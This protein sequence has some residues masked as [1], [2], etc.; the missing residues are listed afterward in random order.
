MLIQTE[1]QSFEQFI[2]SKVNSNAS[3]ENTIQTGE[4][5]I[6]SKSTFCHRYGVEENC[7]IRVIFVGNEGVGKS[8]LVRRLLRKPI[9][10]VSKEHGCPRLM[11]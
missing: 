10:I 8:T 3:E 2:T 5:V 4:N 6:F 9:N 7:H 11:S 1:C